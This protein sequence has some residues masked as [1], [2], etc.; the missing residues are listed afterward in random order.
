MYCC[1]IVAGDYGEVHVVS[2]SGGESLII[3]SP[4]CR[5]QSDLNT[6]GQKERSAC[7]LAPRVDIVKYWPASARQ[8][9]RGPG[10]TPARKKAIGCPFWEAKQYTAVVRKPMEGMMRRA[11]LAS[12][13]GL[14][15][16]DNGQW[17]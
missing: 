10:P 2:V 8:E 5:S 14:V 11:R 13:R 16:L 9:R 4:L 1:E 6:A 15:L 17:A 3:S 12:C 7:S